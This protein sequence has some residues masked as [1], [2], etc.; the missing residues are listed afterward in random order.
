MYE[1]RS[2]TKTYASVPALSEVSFTAVPGEVHALLGMNGAGKSTLV[3]ILVGVEQPSTGTLVLDDEEL[4]LGSARQA[5]EHGIAVVAQ[6]LNVFEH[7]SVQANLFVMREPRRAGFIDQ[8]IMRERSR[9]VLERVGLDLDPRTLLGGLSTGDRQRVAIARALLFD[10]RVLVLDEPTSALQAR[11]TEQL[12]EL[13]RGLRDSGTAIVYVSHFLQE[14]FSV[15]DR[16]TV[17]RDGRTV[18]PGVP[19]A[20]TTLAETVQAMAGDAAA[21]V[22]VVTDP[23]SP[24]DRSARSLEARDLGLIGAFDH[25]SFRASGG[26]VLGIA[27]LEGSGARELLQS[28]FG[29]R[30]ADAGTA[31]LDGDV[32]VGRTMNASVR[33]GVAYVPPDRQRS[34]VMLDSSI[35]DNI[36]QVR[37]ATLGRGG[38]LLTRRALARRAEQRI[39]QLGIKVDQA[40]DRLRVLSG[41]NQQKVMLGKWLEADA[42]VFLLDDPTAAVD[43]HARADIHAVLR[44]L[45]ASGAVVVIASS[46]TDELIEVCDRIGVMYQGRLCAMVENAGLTT[47]ALLEAVNTGVMPDVV[48]KGKVNA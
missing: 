14:V 15:A 10:P 20:S 48:T 31:V 1:A 3:K 12:L 44:G 33:R 45:A 18:V 34:G 26:E 40:G 42:T 37:V 2:I 25:V 22:A 21:G 19:A 28:I 29:A 24:G 46:D 32:E 5:G 38:L 8:A 41:G 6:D 9:R 27:G 17:L 39:R 30:P 43:V 36:V 35:V 47:P 11:E 16:V 23:A 4:V 7:L 13:I